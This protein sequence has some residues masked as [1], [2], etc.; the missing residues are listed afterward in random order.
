MI[1]FK[2]W[3]LVNKEGQ[4]L[5]R[6]I[7]ETRK[8]AMEIAYAEG[9]GLATSAIPNRENHFRRLRRHGFSFCQ[10]TVLVKFSFA[11]KTEE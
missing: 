3:A 4:L 9:L 2:G 5:P 11:Q 10:V 8:K 1:G 7:A 6:T